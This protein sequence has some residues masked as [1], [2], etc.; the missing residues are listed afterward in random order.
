VAHAALAE[1]VEQDARA[2]WMVTAAMA[3][4]GA[5]VE[6][7]PPAEARELLERVLDEGAPAAGQVEPPPGVDREVWELRR[8]LGVA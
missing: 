4:A 7:R 5:T 2:G 3:A 6:E 8:A 1:Q